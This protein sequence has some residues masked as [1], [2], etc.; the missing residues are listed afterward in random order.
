M[1]HERVSTLDGVAA[2][3]AGALAMLQRDARTFISYRIRFVTLVLG[4]FFSLTLFFYLSRLVSF[5]GFDSPDEYYAYAVV[6]LVILQVLNSTLGTPPA[7]IRGELVAGNFERMFHSPL[8]PAA[9]VV[10]ALLFPFVFALVVAMVMLVFAAAVFGLD[11]QWSTLPLAVPLGILGALAFMPF[12]IGLLAVTIV[13]K[14]AAAGTTWVIAGISLI[15]GLYFPTTLLPDWIE[16]ASD[17]QPFTAAV[18]LMRDA[19]VGYPLRD[20]AWVG[21]A[22]LVGFTLVLMPPAL[23]LMRAA[24]GR[25]R[26]AGTVIEY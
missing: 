2:L 13:V 24:I 3:R 8:G 21:I 4:Q 6:G 14:Q 5:R 17:V 19:I 12:G 10:C 23:W 9:A 15:A 26:R 11:L 16:W 22:K 25:S 1:S 7:Q 20:A 18:D